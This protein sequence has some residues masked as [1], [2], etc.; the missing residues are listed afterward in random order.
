MRNAKTAMKNLIFAPIVLFGV[1]L[2]FWWY[3][4]AN[5]DRIEKQNLNYAL[6][7][8]RQTAE[9]IDGEFQTAVQR[10]RTYSYIA[11]VSMTSSDI[12][13]QMLRDMENSSAFDKF[14]YIN[15]N[16]DNLSSDGKILNVSDRN[17]F[18]KGIS[19]ERGMEVVRDFRFTDDSM[20]VFYSPLMRGEEI[21]GLFAGA[22]R[23]EDYLEEMLETSYFGEPADVY[24][25]GS[26]GI[27]IASTKNAS[28]GGDFERPLV[29]ILRAKDILDKNAAEGAR[30]IFSKTAEGGAFFCSKKHTAD[31]ISIL[32]IP[33]TEYVLV[34]MFP[35][36]VSREMISSA[37]RAGMFLQLSLVGLFVIYILFIVIQ[38]RRDR[39]RLERENTEM[40]YVTSGTSALFNR[41]VLVDLENSTYR[42][43]L[44]TSSL[45]KSFPTSGKYSDY[46]TYRCAGMADEEDKQNFTR[47]LSEEYIVEEF[48]AGVADIQYE[49]KLW[50]GHET[51]WEHLN[52]VC[53]ER[54][55]NGKAK[56]L[57]FLRQDITRLKERELKDKASLALAVRKERQYI[58]A[59]MSDALCNYEINLTRDLLTQDIIYQYDGKS[60]DLLELVGL[61]APCSANEWF[62]RWKKFVDADSLE[63]YAAGASV[64]YLLELY[65]EGKRESV[66]EY[67][68][69]F[70]SGKKLCIRQSFFMTT[71]DDTG[72]V[73]AMVIIKEITG[74]VLKQREQMQALQ[75]ALMQAQRANTAKTT[76]LNNMSH[77]IRTP[78]NAIIGFTNIALNHIDNK[79]QVLDSLQKV[80]SS[81]NHLLSL[82]NDILDMSRIESGK[83]QLKEQECSIPELTHNILN[84]IQPQVKAKQLELFIDTVDVVNEDVIA[85]SLKLS[86]VF[87]N[88]LSNAVK[89][90][91]AGGKITFR[92]IQE[93]TF[94][95]GRCDY[96]FIIKDNGIGMTPEF[97]E[98]IFE[99]FE[100]EASVTKTGIQGT[101]LGMA[102][103]K[104]IVDMM[105][106]EIIVNSEKN[107][108]S[109][110]IVKLNLKLGD[111]EKAAAKIKELEGLRALVVDDDADSCES[112]T[113]LLE[114]LGMKAESTT[115][116]NE[117]LKRAEENPY[118]TYIIDWQM[119]E[120][121]GVETARRLREISENASIIVITAYDWSDIAQAAREA[122]ISA[123]CAKPLFMSDLKSALL[124]LNSPAEEQTDEKTWAN[125]DLGGKRVLLVEDNEINREIAEVILT[126]MGLT[127]ET[128]PDGTDAVAMFEKNPAGY[129]SAILM[130]VQMPI[131]DGYEATRTIRANPRPDA[132]T[133]PIIA[134]TANAMEEDKE[135]ALTSGMNAHLA[136]PIDTNLL[137]EVLQKY[138]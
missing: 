67:W 89:Y 131:M 36:A 78:M 117:A 80:L 25:C 51:R 30:D 34:Q 55:E 110:F 48:D 93:S 31:N 52:I 126:E 106:G 83:V 90:T 76:F 10:I 112:V 18:K 84:I 44:G 49:Y 58:T 24:L 116:P 132:Q 64:P 45:D 62:E 70:D 91:P 115:S 101:G 99:P 103:T 92:I 20:I 1:I 118:D 14:Y 27:V 35:R 98:H 46:I 85:D 29:D 33:D 74:Q 130:D 108:G 16:G 75:D 73:M 120:L 97:V 122:G 72:D 135:N 22:Y 39:V 138:I 26:D 17:Y 129:Y 9:R 47:Y 121:S 37:N 119:P 102:I 87:V 105:N 77:D 2:L 81:S 61:K 71:D 6:D 124:A 125:V 15:K 88:L 82:I 53:L 66:I 42:F 63:D 11:S 109:E 111:A 7:S 56:K 28:E 19:G 12:T 79:E 68:R 96:T 133:L 23:S 40:G 38:S 32:Y 137:L 123:F 50:A 136:K 8:A 86:Q 104:N 128:A 94:R 69:S 54:D 95:H 127:V 43:L 41:F 59:T 107:K 13:P 114:Q 60:Y 3:S 100:R 4:S 5:R 57:L 65:A 134:M 113:R 21:V